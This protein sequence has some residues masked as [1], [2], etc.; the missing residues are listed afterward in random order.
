MISLVII[1]VAIPIKNSAMRKLILS[2]LF[3]LSSIVG[4]AHSFSGDKLFISV[5]C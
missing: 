2:F 5:D 1:H 3:V 4:F